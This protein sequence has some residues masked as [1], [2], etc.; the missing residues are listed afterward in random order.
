MRTVVIFGIL[1]LVLA[2]CGCTSV[3]GYSRQGY[4]FGQVDR[5]AVVDVV[6]DVRGNTTKNQVGDMFSMQ[7][8]QKGYSPVERSQVQK[9]LEEQSFQAGEL[10]PED[11]AVKAGRILNVPAVMVVNVSTTSE[12]ISMTAKMLEVES[13]SILWVSTGTGSTGRTVSTILGAGAGAAA[14]AAVGGDEEVVGA[15]AGGVLGGAAGYGLSPQMAKKLNEMTKKMCES[16][17][18]S[19]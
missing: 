15:I 10:T 18:P 1:G 5:V 17:P 16:L 3:E 14:G 12:D 2:V 19:R 9:V 6:G 4:D 11:T 13:G 7:L 8:L